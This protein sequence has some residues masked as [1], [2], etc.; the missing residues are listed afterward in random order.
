MKKSLLIGV[1]LFVG[2]SGA[3]CVTDSDSANP[4]IEDSTIMNQEVTAPTSSASPS[5]EPTFP[6]LPCPKE[7][8]CPM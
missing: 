7:R 6:P 5:S 1:L 2:L 8:P 3:G 4:E